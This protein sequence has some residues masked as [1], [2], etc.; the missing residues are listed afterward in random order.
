MR[1]TPYRLDVR[2]RLP[3]RLQRLEELANNLWYSWD[4]PTRTLFARLDRSLWQIIG[5]SPKAFLRNVDQQRLDEAAE[6][7]VFLNSFHNVLSEYDSYHEAPTKGNHT[8]HLQRE[9]VIAYFCAEFGLHESLPIYSGGL[10]ILA[11]DHTKTASDLRMPFVGVGL[12]YRQGY[13]Q[14]TIDGEGRQHA[15]YADTEFELLP[16]EP[17]L[18]NDGSELHIAIDLPGRRVQLKVWRA[19]VGHVSLCLLDT[20]LP[21]NAPNDRGIAHQLYIGDPETRLEQELMLGVG[22]AGAL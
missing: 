21:E 4:R 14:Q 11:G 2:P 3:K 6:D 7:P 10:G 20:D 12:L 9:D 15:I 16:V 1:G 22:G 18:R 19:R 17:A 5:H 8:A 13:F